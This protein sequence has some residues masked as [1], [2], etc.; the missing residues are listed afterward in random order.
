MEID[1]NKLS[2]YLDHLDLMTYA[3]G[4]NPFDRFRGRLAIDEQVFLAGGWRSHKEFAQYVSNQM[5]GGILYRFHTDDLNEI[6]GEIEK[7]V[8]FP[9]MSNIL[10]RFIKVTDYGIREE[11]RTGAR[12]EVLA[13]EAEK[14]IVAK[15]TAQKL[16]NGDTDLTFDELMAFAEK[17]GVVDRYTLK[18]LASKYTNVYIQELLAAPSARE[19]VYVLSKMLERKIPL[20]EQKTE[21]K[22]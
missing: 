22:K 3:S 20:P 21:E 1:A 11:L 4:Q 2:H 17:A 12:R 13:P 16:L 5:G 15:E 8:E 18:A 19:Q 9:I 6:R 10:G 7:T 14:A